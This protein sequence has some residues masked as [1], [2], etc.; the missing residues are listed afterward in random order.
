MVSPVRYGT[1]KL[2]QMLLCMVNT[3]IN[4]SPADWKVTRRMI[5]TRRA[6]STLIITLCFS[7]ERLKS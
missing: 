7:K 3:S 6:V 4:G 5:P 1:E 2:N